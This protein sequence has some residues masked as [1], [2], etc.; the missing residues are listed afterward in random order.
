[1]PGPRA[2]CLPH[3]ALGPAGIDA[4]SLRLRASNRSI[5][6]SGEVDTEQT[7]SCLS[8]LIQRSLTSLVSD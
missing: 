7:L 1:M 4:A 6:F 8:A 2:P 5:D 3:T